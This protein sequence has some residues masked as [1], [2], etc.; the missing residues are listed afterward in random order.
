MKDYKDLRNG[1]TGANFSSKFSPWLANGSISPRLIYF[2]V[3]KWEKINK[4]NEH[5]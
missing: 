1:F 2:E 5:S 3:K 4:Q